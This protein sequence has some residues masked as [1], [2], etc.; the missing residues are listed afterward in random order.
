MSRAGDG[1]WGGASGGAGKFVN[2]IRM[3]VECFLI[4][5]KKKRGRGR[6]RRRESLWINYSVSTVKHSLSAEYK[7]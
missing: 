4:G 5:V 1:F 7:Q 6:R 3:Q 2:M